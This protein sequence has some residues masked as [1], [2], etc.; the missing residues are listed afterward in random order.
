[1]TATIRNTDG[2]EVKRAFQLTVDKDMPVINGPAD[3]KMDFGR[4]PYTEAEALQSTFATDVVD[5]DLSKHV[6]VT[7]LELLDTQKPGDYTLTYRV[8]NQFGNTTTKDITV[9]VLLPIPEITLMRA[10][11]EGALV[12]K[13]GTT[14]DV[15]HQIQDHV[16]A[17]A[18]H[19]GPID[20]RR[21]RI[22]ADDAN[23]F[24]NGDYHRSG[25]YAYTFEI[26][27]DDRTTG[28]QEIKF[29]IDG[30]DGQ[31]PNQSA[32]GL[33]QG[34]D[35]HAKPYLKRDAIDYTPVQAMGDQTFEATNLQRLN[36]QLEV[37]PHN[38]ALPFTAQIL[39]PETIHF[40]RPGAYKVQ[41]KLAN[42]LQDRVV[43]LTVNI[44]VKAAIATSLS[45][46]KTE[47]DKV[48]DKGHQ[49]LTHPLE[50]YGRLPQ[51]GKR[52]T[53][54]TLALSLVAIVSGTTLLVLRVL[55]GKSK[56]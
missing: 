3:M 47:A 36:N 52:A 4:K 41:V 25:S 32:D 1:V 50:T 34:G 24:N 33:G 35:N 8:T 55:R 20:S 44:S 45:H 16:L 27:D 22:S 15:L 29:V 38:P 7:G 37:L 30:N 18:P 56:E 2:H 17:K 6:H 43:P 13:P 21:L 42:G 23:L 11:R 19:S 54:A 48:V 26:T 53:L 49:A 46:L 12:L 28:A 14:A 39:S 9:K 10:N 51:T 31:S 5:G 40:D